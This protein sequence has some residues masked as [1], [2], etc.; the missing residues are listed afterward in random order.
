MSSRLSAIANCI[1]LVKPNPTNLEMKK[2]RWLVGLLSGFNLA[3]VLLNELLP[4]V[5]ESHC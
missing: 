2:R 3:L 5:C 1:A 4:T